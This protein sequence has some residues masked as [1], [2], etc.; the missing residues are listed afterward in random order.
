MF[1]KFNI[2][3]ITDEHLTVHEVPDQGSNWGDLDVRHIVTTPMSV[4]N[5]I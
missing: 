5:L 3:R 2:S 1:H 4:I